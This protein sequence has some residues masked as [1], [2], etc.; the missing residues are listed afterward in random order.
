M[1]TNAMMKRAFR[2]VLKFWWRKTERASGDG[3]VTVDKDLERWVD[4]IVWRA[5]D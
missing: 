4:A 2:G 1:D 3:E 5:V